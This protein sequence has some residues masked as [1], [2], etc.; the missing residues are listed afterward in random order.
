MSDW[1]WRVAI[2]NYP[3]R[4]S[5]DAVWSRLKKVFA[6]VWGSEPGVIGTVE[7]IGDGTHKTEMFTVNLI[8][9]AHMD[10]LLW[11]NG[12]LIYNY[13][14]WILR[15]NRSME[16]YTGPLSLL[17]SQNTEDGQIDL[18]NFREKMEAIGADM[19]NVSLNNR[20]FVEYLFYGMGC[21]AR[22]RMLWVNTMILSDNDITSIDMWYSFFHFM[23][24]LKHI[25]IKNTNLRQHP[26]MDP[27]WPFLRIESD[28]GESFNGEFRE[29]P[30][31]G[32][33]RG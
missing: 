1:Q 31:Q 24:N 29:A 18:S 26:Y 23:P 7:A 21:C 6:E 13:P 4:A 10:A 9:R 16:V 12:K 14:I 20:D 27:D 3:P 11:L 17:F 32:A 5:P 15:W 8:N 2:T 30:H 19:T 33:W 22:G 28:F 25:I